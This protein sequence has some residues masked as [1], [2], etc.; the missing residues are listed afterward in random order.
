MEIKYEVK[1]V[2][3]APWAQKV[4]SYWRFIGKEECF[5]LLGKSEVNE[6]E[7]QIVLII[8]NDIKSKKKVF[9]LLFNKPMKL[10]SER[11]FL[12]HEMGH[13]KGKKSKSKILTEFYA[14]KWAIDTA[15]KRGYKSIIEEILLRCA[16]FCKDEFADH[17]YRKAANKI[18]KHYQQDCQEIIHKYSSREK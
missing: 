2:C 9:G 7:G 14:D 6:S 15:K 13:I 11:N 12:W 8:R 4:M 5:V 16:G 18:I 1:E 3:F 17:F 10:P